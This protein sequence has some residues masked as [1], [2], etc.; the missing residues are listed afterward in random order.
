MKS[1]EP[2]TWV[3]CYNGRLRVLPEAWSNETAGR[4]RF[5]GSKFF[6]DIFCQSL[7]TESF[8][9]AGN[10][11]PCHTHTFVPSCYHKFQ[12]DDT[13][14][15]S[16]NEVNHFS[17]CLMVVAQ[18]LMLVKQTSSQT[19]NINKHNKQKPNVLEQFVEVEWLVLWFVFGG[20]WA[21]KFGLEGFCR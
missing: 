8:T 21:Q 17:T 4:I 15:K 10:Y 19:S 12:G 14:S 20:F 13:A 5:I 1:E 6:T 16:R 2:L 3:Q 18:D 9:L 11:R 7:H